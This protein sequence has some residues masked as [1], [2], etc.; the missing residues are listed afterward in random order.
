M[1]VTEARAQQIQRV[2]ALAAAIEVAGGRNDYLGTLE[3]HV[4]LLLLLRPSHFPTFV[5]FVRWQ[6]RLYRSGLLQ[7]ACDAVP[8]SAHYSVAPLPPLSWCT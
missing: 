5:A 2:I 3:L 6:V 4:R 7:L 8:D 1:Q